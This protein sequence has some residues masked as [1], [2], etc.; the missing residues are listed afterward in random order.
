MLGMLADKQQ[1]SNGQQDVEPHKNSGES[2][3]HRND[4]SSWMGLGE[5]LSTARPTAL[6]SE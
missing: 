2:L 5:R 6:L 4:L 1:K 3:D